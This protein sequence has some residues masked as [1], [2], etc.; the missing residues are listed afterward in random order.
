M[1][2]IGGSEETKIGRKD[3]ARRMRWERDMREK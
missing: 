3:Q 2:P 1:V